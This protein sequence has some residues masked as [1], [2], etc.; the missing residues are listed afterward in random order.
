MTIELAPDLQKFI[1]K[2]VVEPIRLLGGEVYVFGSRALGTSVKYS[3]LDLLIRCS[4]NIELIKR[5]ISKISEFLEDSSFPYKVD[6]VLESE[7]AESY[8]PSVLKSLVLL[9]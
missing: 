7:L 8:K 1:I 2:N 4:D 5:E 6:I 9:E 3:D